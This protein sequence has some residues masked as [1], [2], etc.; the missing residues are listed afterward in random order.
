[1]SRYVGIWRGIFE[2]NVEFF[3]AVGGLSCFT[4][5]KCYIAP[6]NCLDADILILNI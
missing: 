5:Y 1:M 2:V 3:D 6:E 4:I